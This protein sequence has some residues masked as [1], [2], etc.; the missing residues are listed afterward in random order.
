MLFGREGSADLKLPFSP[1]YLPINQYS[2]FNRGFISIRHA[3]VLYRFKR[4]ARTKLNRESLTAI[5]L[6][7]LKFK[8]SYSDARKKSKILRFDAA[9]AS[10]KP[11]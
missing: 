5:V 9:I 2:T 4:T 10:G 8:N 1:D 3:K 7:D 6:S 11:L